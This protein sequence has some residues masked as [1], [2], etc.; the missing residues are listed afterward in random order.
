MYEGK[1]GKS[2]RA[3]RGPMKS[4]SGL[5][6]EWGSGYGQ[7]Q[8]PRHDDCGGHLFTRRNVYTYICMHTYIHTYI[9]ICTL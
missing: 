4:E 1:K 2:E 7:P 5:E 3:K 9:Y 8:G 6:L